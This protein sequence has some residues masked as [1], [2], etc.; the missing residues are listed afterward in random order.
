M[1][2]MMGQGYPNNKRGK[3]ISLFGRII[4]VADVYDELTAE[5]PYRS[6]LLP[7]EA[8]EY[9]MGEQEVILTQK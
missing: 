9:I 1:K 4:N 3:D 2:D 8:M 7:S 5:R 6:G